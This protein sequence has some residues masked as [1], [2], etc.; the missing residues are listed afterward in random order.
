MRRALQRRSNA[1]VGTG[2]A[3]YDGAAESDTGDEQVKML[4]MLVGLAI[5]AL[6]LGCTDRRCADRVVRDQSSYVDVRCDPGTTAAFVDGY[7]V[8]RCPSPAP[9]P[10]SDVGPTVESLR[11]AGA[12][13]LVGFPG[14]WSPA[15]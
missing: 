14:P 3:D 10:S 8:C 4:R 13:N 2:S 6:D 11:D 9:L 7:I 15:P 5:A 12:P 1:R